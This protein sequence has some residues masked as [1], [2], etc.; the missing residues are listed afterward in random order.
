MYRT[1]VLSLV[2]SLASL[3]ARS[4]EADYVADLIRVADA[5]AQH[6]D[7]NAAY[8]TYKSVATY[9]VSRSS[10]YHSMA[11]EAKGV[12]QQ[13]DQVISKS[14]LT[15]SQ[16][17]GAEA[18][19]NAR[20]IEAFSP[21]FTV[22]EFVNRLQERS[23]VWSREKQ[24]RS[25]QESA[26]GVREMYAKT[27]LGYAQ[28]AAD[29]APFVAIANSRITEIDNMANNVLK[30]AEDDQFQNR[31]DDALKKYQV[32]MLEFRDTPS[33][34][35]AQQQM[36][37]LKSIPNVV[38]HLEFTSA[39]VLEAS[40]K[41]TDALK[42][43]K[44]IAENPRFENSVPQLQ[45]IL[46]V[47]AIENS[48][49]QQGAMHSEMEAAA[50]K[51]G[52]QMLL[53][54]RNYIKNNRFN[55]AAAQLKTIISDFPETSFAKEAN[56]LLSTFST[57]A[58]EELKPVSKPAAVSAKEP[59]RLPESPETSGK[60]ATAVDAR[61]DMPA[62]VSTNP[63]ERLRLAK[64][65][66]L[67]PNAISDQFAPLAKKICGSYLVTKGT[68]N[69]QASFDIKD[70]GTWTFE[71]RQGTWKVIDK[72][73]VQISQNVKVDDKF[74]DF[75]PAVITTNTFKIV[76]LNLMCDT[77]YG[78]KYQKGNSGGV[79]FNGSDFYMKRK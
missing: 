45:A 75:Y 37:A 78:A 3:L 36:I 40:G 71:T 23:G 59:K 25:I 9:V 12:E 60:V 72:D 43:Y 33:S 11:S 70:D 77:V 30:S 39:L 69:W 26:A 73:T 5:A 68:C 31:I 52:P 17:K 74:S 1:I 27:E 49:E 56:V 48:A 22:S 16:L 20:I 19:T 18:M 54:A 6:N 29:L 35:R 57:T 42:A 15:E 8:M 76:N 24:E 7:Y 4:S 41:I 61:N 44:A 58:S 64:D 50:K 14:Q 53:A 38:A 28:M 66:V 10:S 51:R 79:E 34:S 32:L 62:K 21:R 67:P 55:D 2:F 63:T 65:V 47:K 13:Q 46:R